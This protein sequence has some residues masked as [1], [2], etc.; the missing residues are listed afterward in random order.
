MEK[1]RKIGF[2]SSMRKGERR[3]KIKIP[4]KN[5]LLRR[6]DEFG[7]FTWSERRMTKTTSLYR[8]M[9]ARLCLRL[10]LDEYSVL[11][12]RGMLRWKAYKKHRV[13]IKTAL[14]TIGEAIM[15]LRK[16]RVEAGL[17]YLVPKDDRVEIQVRTHLFNMPLKQALRKRRQE[18]RTRKQLLEA[19]NNSQKSTA[20]NNTVSLMQAS[21]KRLL[22]Y[23]LS[24][25]V[26][27]CAIVFF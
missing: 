25:V 20:Y 18:L 5:F 17:F 16:R 6:R 26:L 13:S 22:W 12:S 24:S 15:R 23:T 3:T 21:V 1:Q 10:A 11:K 9:T 8:E 2:I 4:R 27:S 7:T 19:Y 14:R